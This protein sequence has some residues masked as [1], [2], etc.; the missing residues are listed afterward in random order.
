MLL[1]LCV[2]VS[3]LMLALVSLGTD[4]LSELS[5]RTSAKKPSPLKRGGWS[6]LQTQLLEVNRAKYLD[7]LQLDSELQGITSSMPVRQQAALQGNL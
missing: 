6:V 5:L 3:P 2:H 4:E 1:C 7:T